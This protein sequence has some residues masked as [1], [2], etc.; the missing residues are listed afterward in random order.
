MPDRYIKPTEDTL[1]PDP[2]AVALVGRGLRYGSDVDGVD[3]QQRLFLAAVCSAYCSLATH[4]C[5][6]DQLVRLRKALGEEVDG[7]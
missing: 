3:M 5:G 4:P 1:W 6:H 2:K 7:D